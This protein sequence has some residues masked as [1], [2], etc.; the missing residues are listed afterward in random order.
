MLNV[1]LRYEVLKNYKQPCLSMVFTF[2]YNVQNVDNESKHNF[3]SSLESRQITAKL[4]NGLAR[5]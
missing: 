3:S 5:G 1:E 4:E 2:L